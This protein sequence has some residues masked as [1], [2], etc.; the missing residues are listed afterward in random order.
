M[1]ERLS[2]LFQRLYTGNIS[3]EEKEELYVLMQ[4]PGNALE[5]KDLIQQTY[6]EPVKDVLPEQR[7]KDILQAILQTTPIEVPVVH[8]LPRRNWWRVAV[9]ATIVLALAA[10]L[11]ADR[12]NQSANSP[13]TKQI[14]DIAPGKEG[15]VLT[16]ADGTEVLLDTIRNGVVATQAGATATVVNGALQ[17]EGMGEET[18]YNTMR[19]PKGRQYQLTLPDGSKVW[20]NA[21]SSISYPVTFSERERRV[22]VTGEAYFEVMPRQKHPFVV[23]INDRA[24]VD[25]LGTAFNVN[26]YENEKGI[27]TTLV[28]GAVRV[29]NTG[30]ASEILSPGQQAAIGQNIFISDANIESV[31][32][33]TNGSFYFNQVRLEEI[34]RQIER[35]YDVEVVY[36][37]GIPE[38]Q[39]FGSVKRNLSLEGIIRG[40][41]DM[42]VNL[43]LEPGRKLIVTAQ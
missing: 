37:K 28:E 22:K 33:W 6:S 38:V 5:I 39:L 40:L 21:A 41:K 8:S 23:N 7:S 12:I 2:Y 4:D 18:L 3:P 32:A 11:L 16:L 27:T 35:W 29:R 9:A 24:Q 17:Y 36:E 26:A 31:T 19:T 34:M 20:L 25:V 13:A 14:A 10:W 15:A 30:S 43:R 42:G 1:N